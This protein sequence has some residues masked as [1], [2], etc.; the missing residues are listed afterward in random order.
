MPEAR[1]ALRGFISMSRWRELERLGMNLDL[2]TPPLPRRT[3]WGRRLS[4]TGSAVVSSVPTVVPSP[5][6]LPGG[7]VGTALTSVR[8]AQCV[9][10]IVAAG[11]RLRDGPPEI[12][13]SDV[14]ASLIE[15]GFGRGC[16]RRR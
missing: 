1:P 4:E 15:S 16:G 11:P 12:Q 10:R 2:M 3:L 7:S 6:T 8:D 5:G 13:D 14:V 9:G